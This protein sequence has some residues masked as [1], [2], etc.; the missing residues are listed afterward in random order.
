MSVAVLGGAGFIGSN[1][2]DELL[3][4]GFEVTVLDDFSEGT[5]DNLIK[6]PKLEVIKGDIRDFDTVRR[7]VDHKDW[8][9]HL[10]AMSRIQPSIVDPL[11]AI[12]QNI[13]GTANVLEACRQGGVKRVVYSASSSAYGSINEPPMTEDMPTDCLN[14]YSLTKKVGEELMEVYRKLYGLSTV[15]LR[16]FNVYGPKHQEVGDYATV[17]AIFM[18]QLRYG[19]PMTIVGDGEQRRDFTFVTDVVRANIMAAMNKEAHGTFNIG[20]WSNHSVNEVAGLCHSIC[21]PESELKLET[22]PPRLGE[23]QV[24]LANN[25]K[26][27]KVLGWKPEI[28]LEK[29][30]EITHSFQKATA[31]I[32]GV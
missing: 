19:K 1:I 12:H 4:Q 24:T 14:P 32:V 31:I 3:R 30:L 21:D 11:L 26:A 6:H 15:S 16:Y 8:V 29:G 13:V 10:A 5:R 17:I 28:G 22:L 25:N 20:T 9:F 18:R 2:V 27:A 7:V 23:A